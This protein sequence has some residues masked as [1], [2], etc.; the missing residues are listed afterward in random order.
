VRSLGAF[1]R[2]LE[3]AA[4]EA[5]GIVNLRGLAAGVGVAHTTIAA[6]YQILE[7]YLVT[8]RIEPLTA[9]ATRRKLTRSDKYL[10]FDMGVR[11]ARP[12]FVSGA[13]PTAPRWTG[14]LTATDA[15]HRSRS[16]GLKLPIRQ[17]RV[18]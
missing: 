12:A 7:D 4:A 1:S 16:S 2:F 8:E 6:Y 14:S 13:I 10:M 18:T 3:Q 5:G 11:R 15:T 9:S 17:T